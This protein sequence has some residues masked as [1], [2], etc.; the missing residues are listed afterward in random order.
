MSKREVAP[1]KTQLVAATCILVSSKIHDRRPPR[2]EDLCIAMD[3]AF[4]ENQVM[5]ME[6]QVMEL[7][8]WRIR[9]ITPNTFLHYF[10]RLYPMKSLHLRYRS[11]Y[12]LSNCFS[13]MNDE[14]RVSNL[15][16]VDY[17][18]IKYNPSEVA[19]ASILVAHDNRP[20]ISSKNWR[21][22]LE[23]FVS[24]FVRLSL[25]PSH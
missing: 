16:I 12:I 20:K 13:S 25:I 19:L 14:N 9:C 21:R 3:M 22:V 17:E 24:D 8:E 15:F 5:E 23:L 1:C 2:V 6:F 7:L 18:L 10:L 11:C 4:S